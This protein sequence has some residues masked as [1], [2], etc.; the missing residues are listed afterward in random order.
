MI[1][2][3]ERRVPERHDRVA[4]VLVDG[5]A[6]LEDDFRKRRQQAVDELGELVR[7]HVL[8]D[9]REVAHVAEEQRQRP[10]LAA[11]LQLVRVG[12]DLVHHRRRDVIAERAPHFATLLL[13]SPI[14]VDRRRGHQDEEHE[15][16][17]GRIEE[18]AELAVREPPR[19]HE[20]DDGHHAEAAETSA[21]S[22][23]ISAARPMPRR[24]IT[25]ISRAMAKSGRSERPPAENV[26]QHLCVNLESRQ[27]RVERRGAQIHEPR[28]AGADQD[29]HAGDILGV[30]LA[31]QHLPRGNVRG[32]IGRTEL[33]PQPAVEIGRDLDRADADVIEPRRFAKR[34][35]AA[36]VR[37]L[38]HVG[39]RPL[40]HAQRL[41]RQ[42]RHEL[43]AD[44]V[45][46]RHA[47]HH[48]VAVRYPVD[49]ADAVRRSVELRQVA[50]RA[51]KRR[52]E[53]LRII[54]GDGEPGL[55]RGAAARADRRARWPAPRACSPQPGRECR[56]ASAFRRSAAR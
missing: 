11:K 4:H 49:R 5:A 55:G 27:R 33:Q 1:R 31:G 9:R 34:R 15:R 53:R 8:G 17:E 47:P 3:I 28:G 2:I 45:D 18:Q 39:A 56:R 54:A 6:V 24:I 40:R 37:R 35:L 42:R 51:R 10:H 46:Q 12:D 50:R 26:L 29:D 22:R 41:H 48:L 13:H 16:R 43:V 7:V 14:H 52:H 44:P 21:V 30:V 20:D 19:Q 23:G 32:W 38:Q 25:A 36:R